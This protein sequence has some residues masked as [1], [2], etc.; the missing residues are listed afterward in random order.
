MPVCS[1]RSATSCGWKPA[2]IRRRK[3]WQRQGLVPRFELAAGA[4]AA[5]PR[6]RRAVRLRLP[7]PAQARPRVARR[8]ARHQRRFHRPPRLVRSLSAGRRLDRARSDL[9]AA[10]R[11]KPRSARRNPALPQRRADL[12]L[13]EL[14]QCRFRLRH[15]GDADRR[16]SAHHQ[17]LLR[18]ELGAARRARPPGRC[19]AASRTTCG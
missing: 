17:A 5:P 9:G 10:D 6:P 16:A 19:G 13:C 8:P 18:R 2:S 14:R 4:G 7:D 11:R 1:A 12:G 3:R 15:E